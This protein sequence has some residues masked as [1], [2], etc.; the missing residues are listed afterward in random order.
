MQSRVRRDA[1]DRH[2]PRR[3]LW[4]RFALLGV[5]LAVIAALFLTGAHRL[6]SFTA[7]VEYHASLEAL[8]ARHAPFAIVLYLLAY[9]ASVTLSLPGAAV[10]TVAGGFLFG[11]FLGGALA[12]AAS[13]L[14]AAGVFVLAR[15]TLG[16]A[17]AERAGPALKKLG[18]GFREGAWSYLLF[19]RFV[20]VFPFWLVN[21]A[22]ALFHVPFRVF[23]ATTLIGVTPATFAFAFAGAAFARI[24]DDQAAAMAACR[25]SGRAD[26][27][28]TFDPAAVITPELVIAL[29]ALGI[30]SL[31]PVLMRLWR[32]R[33]ATGLA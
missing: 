20:P 29:V 17:L 22:P 26:C 31:I 18:K 11:G 9:A 4:R 2:A 5:I 3:P 8:V 33:D 19:L 32:R 1:H 7:L 28:P 30:A 23:V 21:L 24:V 16:G 12:V 25:A 10:F 27:A 14:G 6:V 15:T 13:T